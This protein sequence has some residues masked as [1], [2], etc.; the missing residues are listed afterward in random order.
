M[1]R[2]RNTRVGVWLGVLAVAFYAWLPHHFATHVVNAALHIEAEPAI[3]TGE[4]PAARP[5]HDRSH[6]RHEHHVCPICAAAAA[7]ASPT[8]A[9]LAVS[10][11]LPLPVSAAVTADFTDTS[12]A[13][14]VAQ[15]TPYAPRG[16]PLAV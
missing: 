3:S 15:L 6:H 1:R 16:P 10:A 12:A 4:G 9:M 14:R 8:V 13:L 2:L 11:V 5:G 7:S